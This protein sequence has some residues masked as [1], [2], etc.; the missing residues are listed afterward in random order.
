MTRR[1]PDALRPLTLEPGWAPYAEGS[2]LIAAGH[3]RVLCTAS[4]AETVPA[5]REASGKG[6]VTA[7]WGASANNRRARFYTLTPAGER[8]VT[9][10]HRAFAR[11]IGAIHKVLDAT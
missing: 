11:L 8:Q 9:T 4:V 5:W 6:W 3:T 2:C 1:A 7:E 10:E